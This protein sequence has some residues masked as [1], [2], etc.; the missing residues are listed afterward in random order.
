[1]TLPTFKTGLAADENALE[2]ARRARQL[3]RDTGK[4]PRT[5]SYVVV[6]LAG[7]NISWSFFWQTNTQIL[8]VTHNGLRVLEETNGAPY[9]AYRP[10]VSEVV[11][12]LRLNMI[13]DDLADV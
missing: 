8:S 11:K 2:L 4:D 3:V 13:L 9:V 1:M 12:I 6:E 5:G 10:A 7:I